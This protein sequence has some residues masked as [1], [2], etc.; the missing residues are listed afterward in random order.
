MPYFS[1]ITPSFNQGRY[2]ATCL[3]SVKQQGGDDYEHIVIDNCSTD[4]TRDVLAAWSQDRHLRLIVEPDHGQSEAV[5]KGLR[6]AQGEVICWLNSDDAYP[7]ETFQKLRKIFE[8]STVDVVFGDA[9]QIFDDGKNS[10]QQ[11]VADFSNRYDF[12]RWWSSRVRLHQPA[13]FFRRSV[14]Q[15]IGLLDEKLHY[16]M[17]YEYWWRMSERYHFHYVPEAL[18][19]Q[20]RQL[21]SK[22]MKAWDRVLEEREKIFSPYYDLLKE[23]KSD[24]ERERST[25]LAQHYLLQAYAMVGTNRSGAWKYF[26]KAWQQGP[27]QALKKSSWGLIRQLCKNSL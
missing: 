3:E 19:I 20:H 16:A 8:D 26:K 10:S 12:I 23:K 15:S 6:L 24:L 18:A 1:I 22:T 17:D 27:R 4:E 14:M 5:N 9:L 21:D 25:T 2:L 11:A 7:P 13:I